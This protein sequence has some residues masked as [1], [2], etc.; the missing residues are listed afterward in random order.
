[1]INISFIEILLSPTEL[2]L[3]QAVYCDNDASKLTT[4]APDGSHPPTGLHGPRPGLVL[5]GSL[6]RPRLLPQQ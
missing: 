4:A 5:L 2:S 1:M 3:C 6:R